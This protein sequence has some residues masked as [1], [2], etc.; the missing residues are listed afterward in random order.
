MSEP[1]PPEA[2]ATRE[3]A[4]RLAS[5]DSDAGS[6]SI[7]PGSVSLWLEQLKAGDDAAAYHLWER[8]RPALLR[9]ARSRFG[10]APRR[11]MDEE[12]VALSV[13][14]ALVRNAAAGRLPRL[15]NRADL[16]ALLVTITHRKVSNVLRDESCQK[17]G[18]GRVTVERDLRTAAAEN[19]C[20]DQL[21]GT[22]PSA[23]FLIAMNEEQQRLV[24]SLRNPTLQEVARR[25]IEGDSIEEI[26][27][28]LGV[29]KRTVERKL[30]LIH[31]KWMR[32]LES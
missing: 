19:F 4:T 6:I 1:T 3:S 9:Q 29:V 30:E 24:A 18:S 31:R 23:E 22:L 11:M 7:D 21:P 27:E 10:T 5:P 8:Y 17:R 12:D 16:W 32:E 20:L 26:A 28:W 2:P 13:F 14:T 15:D 25:R